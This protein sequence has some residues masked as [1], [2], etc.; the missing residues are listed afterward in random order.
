MSGVSRT[1]D[2]QYIESVITSGSV[3]A[4][5]RG[6]EPSGSAHM[7]YLDPVQAAVTEEGK[8]DTES[9][10]VGTSDAEEVQVE[11]GTRDADEKELPC[12]LPA[13]QP[14][15]EDRS[16]REPYSEQKPLWSIQEQMLRLT[17]Q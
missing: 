11:V 8:F 15:E 3:L 2:A 9:V 12:A 1:G 4:V 13:T 10:E 7:A 16:E 6:G 14:N 5:T 17:G